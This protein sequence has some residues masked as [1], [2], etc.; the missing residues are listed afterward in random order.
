MS[1]GYAPYILNDMKALVGLGYAGAKVDASG[2]LAM[3]LENASIGKTELVNTN[4]HKKTIKFKYKQR[5]LKNRVSSTQNCDIDFVSAYSEQE[6]TAPTT[7]KVG[8]HISEETMALYMDEAS[9]RAKLGTAQTDATLELMEILASAHNAINAAINDSLLASVTFGKNIV[10]GNSGTTETTVNF[11]PTSGSLDLSSGIVQILTDAQ[12]S[13]FVGK[14]QI[15]G[16][17]LFNNYHMAKMNSL[18]GVGQGLDLSKFQDY[19]FFLDWGVPS[20]AEWG[21][22][23]NAIGVFDPGAVQLVTA[24]DLQGFRV[25]KL[26]NSEFFTLPMMVDYGY[27]QTL[28]NVNC[29]IREIDCPTELTDG[30]EGGT[31]TFDAG[32]ALYVWVNFG[33]FQPETPYQSGDRLYGA[34]GALLYKATNA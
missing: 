24:T 4:G 34:N 16:A 2:F 12:A 17:G 20:L 15:V 33:L 21:G 8:F 10:S 28:M 6:I 18:V 11:N 3:A 29:Q 1:L 22:E 26:A 31:D 19:K 5:V 25:K 27:G 23:A 9:N 14:P 7:K 30:Y 13:G 32:Y